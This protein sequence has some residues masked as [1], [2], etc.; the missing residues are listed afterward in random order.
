[1]RLWIYLFRQLATSCLLVTAVLCGAIWLVL[2]LR[3]IEFALTAG[4]SFGLFAQVM[5]SMLPTSLPMILPLGV[6]V[7]LLFTYNRLIQ[8]SELIVM[9]AAGI[10]PVS[11]AG[12][13]LA[14]VAVFTAVGL[15]LTMVISPIANR[16]VVRLQQ[17]M[18]AGL[19]NV[20][21]R[22][23]QFTEIG[24]G[25]TVY[26]R[27]RAGPNELAGLVVHD[28]RTPERPSTLVAARGSVLASGDV[29][30]LLVR[31]G[32]RQELDRATGRVSE[33][34][35]ERYAIEFELPRPAVGARVPDARER[36]TWSL[37]T[38]TSDDLA[39]ERSRNRLVVE[40]NQRLAMPL[41][42]PAMALVALILLLNEEHNR[43][44]R[45]RRLVAATAI[46]VGLQVTLL[47]M[48]NLSVR[49]ARLVPLIYLPVLAPVAV[50]IVG[51]VLSGRTRAAR[52]AS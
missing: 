22:E 25:L 42:I 34:T 39:S 41:L 32:T 43:R 23:G 30:R 29:L 11:L 5:A 51:S 33:L 9:R 26:V 35:F 18:R 16:E 31:D 27:D 10:G 24:S 28:L 6:L 46:A 40:F 44:G 1:M 52:A 7:G 19:S 48:L 49:D 50:A 2:S 36:A 38:P 21:L 17:I 45:T 14:V 37:L 12:P 47:A 4:A 15:F 20:V 8:E 13:A 3:V